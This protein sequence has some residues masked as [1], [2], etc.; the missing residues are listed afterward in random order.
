MTRSRRSCG[1]V[2]RNTA[3]RCTAALPRRTT[4]AVTRRFLS[5]VTRNTAKRRIAALPRRTTGAVTR[6]SLSL[7]TRNTAG[8]RT[9]ALSRRTTGYFRPWER[10]EIR[11][12]AMMRPQ[13]R[14]ALFW[15]CRA[16]HCRTLHGSPVTPDNRRRHATLS[17]SCHTEHCRTLHGSPATP[18]N[19]RRHATLSISCHTEH[20][21]T[22]HGSPVTP[23]NRVLSAL[24][25]RRDALRRND[26]P[27]NTLRAGTLLTIHADRPFQPA[28]GAKSFSS[29]PMLHKSSLRRIAP[30]SRIQGPC[31]APK[32]KTCTRA[33]AAQIYFTVTSS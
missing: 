14:C 6:R 25:T 19:R 30:H 15:P 7:V 2:A 33:A 29:C 9:A 32:P 5:L 20:C 10:G 17:T 23:D 28:Q 4:G 18:D 24:G 11:C 31:G 22:P 21:G 16:E 26:A 1:S 13:I 27:A 8:R 12:A 3:G